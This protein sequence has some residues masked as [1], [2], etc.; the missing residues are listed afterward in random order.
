MLTNNAVPTPRH[1]LTV[2]RG[3]AQP[4][5]MAEA[6]NVAKPHEGG[7]SADPLKPCTPNFTAL[8]LEEE[9]QA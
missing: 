7:H 8:A 4:P 9:G 2:G 5:K 1:D 3:Y 6:A